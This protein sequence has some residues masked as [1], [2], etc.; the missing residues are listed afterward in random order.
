[1][2]LENSLFILI[3]SVAVF[4]IMMAAVAIPIIIICIRLNELIHT[5]DHQLFSIV[6][7]L[8]NVY[9]NK[10]HAETAQTAEQPKQRRP[11]VVEPLC[12]EAI[13]PTLRSPP[14][15]QGGFGT[16]ITLNEQHKT[17]KTGN[18]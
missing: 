10:Q 7:E 8:R 13:A 3:I 14:R 1:M 4:S 6:G 18:S 9:K 15:P 17:D 12:P 16:K 2:T 5:V 11:L